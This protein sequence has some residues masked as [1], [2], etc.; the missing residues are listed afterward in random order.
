M[1]WFVI[2]ATSAMQAAQ[3]VVPEAIE[4]EERIRDK[5]VSEPRRPA[6]ITERDDLA[7]TVGSSSSC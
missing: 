4:E 7:S 1:H 5:H 2:L 6:S 3:T